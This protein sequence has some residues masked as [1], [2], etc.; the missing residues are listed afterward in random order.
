MIK[1]I[2]ADQ[3]DQFPRLKDTMFK[4]RAEQFKVRHGWEVTV[5]DN[6]H[7]IDQYD[8]L[9]PLYAIW[10]LEDGTHGG[11]I[12]V[13]PTVG[14]TMINEHFT[15]LTDGVEIVSPTIWECTRYCI[16]PHLEQ[17][18]HGEVAAALMLAG[19]ELG[20]RFGLTSSIGIVYAHTLAIYKRIGWM[21]EEI[22]RE[23]EGREAIV[24]CLWP[25]TKEVK[26]NI[27]R[28]SRIEP[29]LVEGWFEAS[30]PIAPERV[31]IAA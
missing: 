23:G 16:S 28:K 22:G 24:A 8:A 14:R 25:T 29:G 19:C 13:L 15:H 21:P 3:L 6:G 9:N 12:R 1:Y 17:G 4:D 26:A 20:I 2:Y 10:E 30:F 7:E 11:S 18:R 27:C 5:D 31:E